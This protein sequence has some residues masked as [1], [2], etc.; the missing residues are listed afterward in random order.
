[1]CTFF[2]ERPQPIVHK[3]HYYCIA[4][5]VSW[6]IV[7]LLD[8]EAIFTFPSANALRVTVLCCGYKVEKLTKISINLH[9]AA[10]ITLLSFYSPFLPCLSLYSYKSLIQ[11]PLSRLSWRF[12]VRPCNL[13]WRVRYMMNRQP[14]LVY[15]ELFLGLCIFQTFTPIE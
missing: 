9:P 7:S 1:M 4:T 13:R 10:S 12:C 11:N 15:F 6:K 8:N 5:K 2:P 3:Q 14:V